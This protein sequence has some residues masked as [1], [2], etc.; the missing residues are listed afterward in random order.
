VRWTDIDPY[1]FHVS[2]WPKSI[3]SYG[4]YDG[5][6]RL[7]LSWDLS[8]I[9]EKEKKQAIKQWSEKLHEL[10]NV[11]WL[12]LWSH[13]TPPLIEAACRMPGLE[14]LQIKWSNVRDISAIGNLQQLRYLYVGSSTR[15]E[16][17]E[18][19]A[20]LSNLRLLEIENFKL[21]SDF[22]PLVRLTSL[23]SLA[24]TGSMWARQDVGTLETFAQMTWLQ[25]LAVD[26]SKVKTLR[27]LA[28]LRRLKSID[29]G[30]RLPMSE[31]AWLSAMLPDTECRWFMP[32]LNL[33][34]SGFSRCAKCKED[35]KVM[36]TGKGAK[37]LCRFCNSQQLE[38]H[39][40]AF[41]AVKEQARSAREAAARD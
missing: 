10:G 22:S 14:C 26:T 4:D 17:I 1:P 30:N 25:S 3:A 36:L 13:V 37:V 23:E 7:R 18:S 5:G 35:S 6:E 24:V 2:Q 19:L 39:E 11:R 20:A 29:I 33:S 31:Y 34:G 21:I 41:D 27:P 38:R 32:Y 40:A 15:I 8:R 12:S 9:T 16:S 28:N